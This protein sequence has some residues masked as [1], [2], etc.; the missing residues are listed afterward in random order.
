MRDLAA[1][2]P[3]AIGEACQ[4]FITLRSVKTNQGSTTVPRPGYGPLPRAQGNRRRAQLSS[5]RAS[6][7]DVLID[8][9]E[10]CTVT[11]LSELIRQHPNTIREHL[12]GLVHDRLVVRTRAEGQARGRPAWLYAA[13]PD[14]GT[15]PGSREYAALASALAAQIARTSGQPHTDAIDAGRMWGAELA[16]QSQIRQALTSDPAVI[17]SNPARAAAAPR[18]SSVRREVVSLLDELGFA[19]TTDARARIVK[20]RRCP[21]LEA[22]H[23]Q[24]EVVCG[25]HLGIVRG[26][27]EQLGNDPGQTE[28]T[29]LQAFSEPGACR[30]DLLPRGGKAT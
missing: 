16:R 15:E 27:L 14:A 24:T 18:G 22:A 10:P 17:K 4:K 5:A 1:P 3:A 29:S 6:I 2:R 11:A 23:Q 12:D 8:Q 9:P 19:P 26:A 28:R 7:L 25:V 13:S 30:L 20:L 21:L